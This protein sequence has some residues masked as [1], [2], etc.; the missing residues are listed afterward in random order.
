MIEPQITHR[1]SALEFSS[2]QL[3]VLKIVG[4]VGVT[5]GPYSPSSS[6][7]SADPTPL[8]LGPN[9]TVWGRLFCIH[10]PGLGSRFWLYCYLM[11]L[12]SECDFFFPFLRCSGC[13]Y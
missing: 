12:T 8:L 9:K 7:L 10:G 11:V 4:L 1:L 2:E 3:P 5:G 6:H 13:G